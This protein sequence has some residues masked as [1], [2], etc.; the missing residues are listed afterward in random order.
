MNLQYILV[1]IRKWGD[2][3]VKAS[4]LSAYILN[5]L[6]IEDLIFICMKFKIE[7]NTGRKKQVSAGL[8]F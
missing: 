4:I 7:R 2:Q 6:I 5:S 8:S 1:N 3:V